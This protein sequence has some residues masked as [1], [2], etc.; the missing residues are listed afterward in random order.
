[1]QTFS[2]TAFG[3]LLLGSSVALA[4]RLAFTDIDLGQFSNLIWF[5]AFIGA[6]LG[7][8]VSTYLKRKRETK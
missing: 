6:G 7:A 4:L 1:M 2:M 8:G 3:A 5:S